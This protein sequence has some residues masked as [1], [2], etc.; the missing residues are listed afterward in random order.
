MRM[1]QK[2]DISGLISGKLTAIRRSGTNS[3]GSAIWEC[4]CSCGSKRDVK[5]SYIK[6]G[7][8][9]HCGCEYLDKSNPRKKHGMY[10]TKEYNAW[11]AMKSRCYNKDYPSYSSYGGRGIKVCDEWLNNFTAF[12]EYI[13]DAPS[14]EYSLDRINFDGDYEPGNVRWATVYTQNNNRGSNR[15]ITYNGETR[16]ISEWSRHLDINTATLFSRLDKYG[17]TIERAFSEKSR[18]QTLRK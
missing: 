2:Y 14:V 15:V 1:K 3:S 12:Y 10:G 11:N 5:A 16:T 18:M 13:G 7:K 17:W 4:Q 8:V 6:T 9:T